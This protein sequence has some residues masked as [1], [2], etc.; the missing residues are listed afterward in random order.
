MSKPKLNFTAADEGSSILGTFDGMSLDADITNNNGLDIPR[1]VWETVFSSK[2]YATGI[3]H[4]WFIGF[5][6]H[7]DDPGCQDFKNA[8][9]VMT[10]GKLEDGKI[11]ASFNLVDSPVGRIVNTFRKAGVEFGISVRGAGDITDNVV[12]AETFVFRGFDLVAFP[13]YEEAIPEFTALAASTDPNARRAYK[14]VCDTINTELVGI[15]SASAIKELKKPFAPRSNIF[16]NLKT[17]EQQIKNG[18]A[19]EEVE[20]EPIESSEASEEGY[21][22]NMVQI[23]NCQKIS[24][25][26]QLYIEAS[27]ENAQLRRQLKDLQAANSTAAVQAARKLKTIKRMTSEQLNDITATTHS[28]Q[29]RINGLTREVTSLQSE[30]KASKR[31]NLDYKRKV[32]SVETAHEDME[33]KM[34][35]TVTASKHTQSQASKL[36]SQVQDLT[37]DLLQSKQAYANLYAGAVG[38]NPRS[39]TITASMSIVQIRKQISGA[40]NTVG[41]PAAPSF[42]TE[43]LDTV[44][45]DDDHDEIVTL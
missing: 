33:Y 18:E 13:A 28:Q 41:I 44:T 21:G 2:E 11:Y 26:T 8:C 42:D 39:L 16:K 27:T 15:T 37:D 3:A 6:G 40:T 35:E 31:L 12:E 43:A 17:R 36:L 10:S 29:K 14:T 4:G 24:S 38:V 9:I 30:V 19:V 25:M 32:Q 22:A 5:L 45:D 7:P 1:D 34:R 20:G 23:V